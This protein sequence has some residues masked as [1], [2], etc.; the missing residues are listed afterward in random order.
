M[1]AMAITST[2]IITS[3]GIMPA[4]PVSAPYV[5]CANVDSN[6]GI[7]FSVNVVG[8]ASAQVRRAGTDI[9]R[10]HQHHHVGVEDEPA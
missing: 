3:I 10:L 5:V 8:P 4:E 1:P 6:M 9:D 2:A 7:P